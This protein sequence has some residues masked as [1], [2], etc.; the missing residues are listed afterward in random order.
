MRKFSTSLENASPLTTQFP[1][2]NIGNQLKSVAN[3]INISTALGVGRQV[4][5]VGLGGFDTHDD[6]AVDLPRQQKRYADAIT[7]FYQATVEMGAE[8]DVTTFTAS[9]FGRSLLENGNGTDHG[10]GAH[11]FVIGG[12]VNGNKIYGD[13]PAPEID[14]EFD[15]GNGRLI[16]QVAVEQYAATLG[17]WF[18]LS[19]AELQAALPSLSNFTEKNLGFMAPQ[20]V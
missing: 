6:Q 9:D 4:F 15:S 7:A 8:N 17:S 12:A 5:F 2:G 13:I 3:T 20:S 1:S 18:G 16:P 11:H 19:P 14:H 10:W